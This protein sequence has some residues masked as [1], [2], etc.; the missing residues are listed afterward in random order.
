MT[1]GKEP[2]DM[3]ST[4]AAEEIGHGKGSYP[5]AVSSSMGKL[6][7]LH[8]MSVHCCSHQGCTSHRSWNSHGW[9]TIGCI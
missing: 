6:H 5:V 4:E 2:N 9:G 1:C 7:I 3:P 8:T